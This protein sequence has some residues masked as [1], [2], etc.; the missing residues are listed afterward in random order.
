MSFRSD[1]TATL[2]S[3]II[4][5]LP[6]MTKNH[7]Y[8]LAALYPYAPSPM[9]K[10]VYREKLSFTSTRIFFRRNLRKRCYYQL[11]ACQAIDKKLTGDDYGYTSDYF[12][13]GKEVYFEDFNAEFL[14]SS[15]E[16]K[17]DYYLCL[18]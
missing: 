18:Y 14:I 17:N 13:T 11:L 2:N 10:M 16:S 3:L 1:R 12:K 5:Y 9:A 4:N 7:T 8:I 6:A 15:V